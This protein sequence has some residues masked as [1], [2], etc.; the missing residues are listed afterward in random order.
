MP[1]ELDTREKFTLTRSII[2]IRPRESIS[3]T[4]PVCSQPSSSMVSFVFF[5]SD[6]QPGQPD[7]RKK[8]INKTFVI[9]SE[10]IGAAHTDF[11]TRIGFVFR[12]I[13]HGRD[14]NKLHFVDRLWGTN[15]STGR[16]VIRPS[17]SRS[18]A[19]LSH[20]ITAMKI[21]LQTK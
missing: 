7:T 9:A 16:R 1:I 5:S 6:I 13:S 21:K 15:S 11:S 12:G 2:L 20:S 10:T 3:A 8:T 4:S 18:G 14:I 17:F 19:V